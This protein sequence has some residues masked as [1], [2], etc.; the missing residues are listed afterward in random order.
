MTKYNKKNEIQKVPETKAVPTVTAA[1]CITQSY[2]ASDG[3]R[4]FC[5]ARG[6][7]NTKTR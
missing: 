6:R 1:G 2:C 3:R 7:E 5:Q 4:A